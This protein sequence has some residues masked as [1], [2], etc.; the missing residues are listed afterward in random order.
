MATLLPVPIPLVTI[1]SGKFW[2]QK[3]REDLTWQTVLFK[4]KQK[5]T[6]TIFLT[7]MGSSMHSVSKAGVQM[8]ADSSSSYMWPI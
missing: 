4:L 3:K 8:S 1:D 7:V 5:S 2:Q 6:S